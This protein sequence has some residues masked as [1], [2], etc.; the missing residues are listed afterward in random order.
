[1]AL[2][3]A[4]VLAGCGGEEPTRSEVA[5]R[6]GATTTT[7]PAATTSAAGERKQGRKK[8]TI[9][10]T[11]TPAKV[12]GYRFCEQ[13]R[14][15]GDRLV[16]FVGATMEAREGDGWRV[17]AREPRGALRAG[18]EWGAWGAV[19][20]SPDGRTILAEWSTE[21]DTHYSF[22]VPA[23]GGR[24]RPVTGERDWRKSPPSLPQGWAPDGRARVWVFSG[25]GCTHETQIEPGR[26]LVDP[27][28]GDLDY[29]APL[30]KPYRS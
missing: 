1:M 24:P 19:W 8:P 13:M 27:E 25:G 29:A 17:L 30:P 4:G 3:V 18:K 10:T 6:A 12:A 14:V 15:R 5:A 2:A 16:G 21:C 26:Y 20:P 23:E 22:F 11:C 28:A 7:A 9:E